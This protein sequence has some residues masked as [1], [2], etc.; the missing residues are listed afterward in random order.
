MGLYDEEVKTKVG[1]EE[2]DMI[3]EAVRKGEIDV[4]KMQDIAQKLDVGGNHQRRGGSDEPEL[5]YIFSDWYNRTI[6]EDEWDRVRVLTEIIEILKDPSV[7]LNPLAGKLEQCLEVTKAIGQETWDMIFDAV[8]ADK[9]NRERM[10]KMNISLKAEVVGIHK[11]KPR[12]VM[13]EILFRWRRRNG[14]KGN[15]IDI[16]V[17]AFKNGI[18][19]QE[20][21]QISQI[22]EKL[23]E[24][25]TLE[26]VKTLEERMTLEESKKLEEFKCPEELLSMQGPEPHFYQEKPIEDILNKEIKRRMEDDNTANGKFNIVNFA[27]HNVLHILE[28]CILFRFCKQTS[29]CSWRWSGI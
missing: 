28:C 21:A 10:I 5:R 1:K 29:P 23:E 12:D 26:E 3:L 13:R 22:L 11:K 16:L 15:A 4:I 24:L 14:A 20:S 2:L 7:S 6:C 9:I 17:E 27:M 19:Q 8:R 25:M 18:L